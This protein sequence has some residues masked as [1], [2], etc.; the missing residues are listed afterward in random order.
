MMRVK[1]RSIVWFLIVCAKQDM[2][3]FSHAVRMAFQP[4]SESGKII[5]L[6]C[7]LVTF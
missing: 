6:R 2:G 7:H 1:I 4:V 3:E 5:Y